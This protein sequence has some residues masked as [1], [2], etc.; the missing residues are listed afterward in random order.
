MARASSITRLAVSVVLATISVLSCGGGSGVIRPPAAVAISPQSVKLPVSETAQFTARVTGT[1]NPAVTWF[2]NDVPGG[3]STAATVSAS[4]L[5]TAPAVPPSPNTVTVKATSVPTPSAMGTAEVTVSNPAPM[6]ESIAPT[7]TI[8]GPADVSLVATGTGFAIQSV[9]MLGSTALQTTL[10]ASTRL[11]AV[12]PAVQLANAGTF[13]VTVQ[14]PS[15][16]GGVSQSASFT[17][18]HPPAITSA[19]STTFVVGSAGSFTV[20]ATGFPAP[21][22]SATGSLPGGV[23]FNSA[24]GVLSGTPTASAGG[25]C[26]LT[27]K[28][29]NSVGTDAT[30]KFTLTVN[31]APAITSAANST[32]L[33]GTAGTFTVTVTGYPA[34]T[35]SQ[36]GTL[37]SGVTFNPS[38]GVL[39]GNPAAAGG[40]TFGLTLEAADRVSTH[41]TQIF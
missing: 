14:T 2:V 10:D 5:Y 38:T 7:S 25:T 18:T 27:F 39:G 19:T 36:T 37:P 31:Q 8:A 40:G 41:C 20:A 3:T 33:V 23:T 24:T 21:T 4:G 13:P 9:V 26:N 28:A 30:Q 32:F 15:P 22:L 29:S 12:V 34:P 6:L 16:G 35:L 17:V 11:T 1:G